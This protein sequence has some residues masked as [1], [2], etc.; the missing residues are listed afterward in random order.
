MY[1]QGFFQTVAQTTRIDNLALF[2][3]GTPE[4]AV[5]RMISVL[6]GQS[7]AIRLW[8]AVQVQRRLL[9]QEKTIEDVTGSG[10]R[11]STR[12]IG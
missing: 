6:V 1:A 2:T 8:V 10:K 3:W 7:G 5:D 11:E 9:S 4:D 12:I